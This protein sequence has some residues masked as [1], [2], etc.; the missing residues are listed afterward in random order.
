MRRLAAHLSDEE[1]VTE[2]LLSRLMV[3]SE[4]EV[5]SSEGWYEELAEEAAIRWWKEHRPKVSV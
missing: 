1:L 2:L 4:P 3:R 5:E